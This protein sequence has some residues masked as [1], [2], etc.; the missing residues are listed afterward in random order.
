MEELLWKLIAVELY[1]NSHFMSL[2]LSANI[3]SITRLPN[4]IFY[5]TTGLIEAVIY[6]LWRQ[7]LGYISHLLLPQFT[8]EVEQLFVNLT[9]L[10]D[11]ANICGNTIF[12][13]QVIRFKPLSSLDAMFCIKRIPM[14]NALTRT[15]FSQNILFSTTII[16]STK[17][18]QVIHAELSITACC[19]CPSMHK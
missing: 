8:Y 13:K 2:L 4:L 15:I 6:S 5:C 7:Y 18:I 16:T 1:T 9:I 17:I 14:C 12:S 10:H 3:N 19:D 11:G